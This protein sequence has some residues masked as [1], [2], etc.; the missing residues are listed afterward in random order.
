MV[1][2]LNQK[3]QQRD[4]YLN[5]DDSFEESASKESAEPDIQALTRPDLHKTLNY[6]PSRI[7]R[8]CFAVEAQSITVQIRIV[9]RITPCI[10][11]HHIVYRR[12]VRYQLPIPVNA[13]IAVDAIFGLW[14]HMVSRIDRIG[15]ACF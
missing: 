13:Q 5:L 15:V 2:I 12:F 7:I 6:I 4:Q 9:L 11:H 3:T 8:P 10:L 14:I 1:D